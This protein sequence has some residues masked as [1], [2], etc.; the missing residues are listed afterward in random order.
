MEQY[1]IKKMSFKYN[2]NNKETLKDI[3][4]TVNKGDFVTIF[5][6]S[7]SG[8][9]TLLSLLK[10][11]IAPVGVLKGDILFEGKKLEDI[12]KKDSVLKIGF[13]F[14]DPEAQCV[15]DKVYHE[16]AFGLE[17]LGVDSKTI[18]LRVSEVSDF[19]HIDELFY[20]DINKISGGQKQL[21][22]LASIMVMKPEVIILDEPTSQVS[23]II[24]REFLNTLGMINREFGTTIILS[25][26][27]LFDVIKFS[28]KLVLMDEGRIIESSD[29]DTV[30]KKLYKTEYFEL[31]P[32]V[33]KISLTETEGKIVAHDIVECKNVIKKNK[34]VEKKQ[35][36]DEGDIV[37]LKDIWFKY[38]DVDVLRDLTIDIKKNRI[39]SIIGQNGSGKSTL[40]LL[41]SDI[42]KNYRG[43][44]SKA[45]NKA[46]M[47]PQNVKTL[48]TKDT[49][50]LEFD[51]VSGKD[52]V[53]KLFE[54]EDL[55]DK[56]PFDLSGGE[57]QK[58]AIAK[59]L[60]NKPD[61]LLLDE[62]TKAMDAIFK[63]KFGDKLKDIA[64]S[65]VTVVL[66][67]HDIDFAASISDYMAL[68]FNGEIITSN[69]TDEFLNGNM[70]YNTIRNRLI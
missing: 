51:G 28:N 66:V 57:Q 59:L 17:S 18:K 21:I 19:F 70:F 34:I 23:P 64:Q 36:K 12:D 43:K 32:E 48:F 67:T 2:M 58:V 65:G 68:M 41:I 37:K 29:V 55:F 40:L 53:I 6:K 33:V 62:P 16:L 11:Q 49:V 7:G 54:L 63:K 10:P 60:L 5:G 38:K 20:K 8:K 26:H 52:E 15:T 45:F 69:T 9:S 42:I 61:L 27:R 13:V 24:A 14:Q 56:H 50:K 47:L 25:E 31:L 22:N 4:L 1:K 30:C 3:D 46:L 44:K 35:I 39:T